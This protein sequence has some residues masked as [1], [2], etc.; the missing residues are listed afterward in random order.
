MCQKMR[1]WG[2]REIEEKK[3][4][5]GRR[6][7]KKRRENSNRCDKDRESKK[8]WEINHGYKNNISLN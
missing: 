4:R 1:G 6:K 2:K 8:K 7:R 5:R 3:G